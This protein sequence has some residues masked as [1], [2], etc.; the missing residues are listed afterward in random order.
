MRSVVLRF[1]VSLFLLAF[2][3]VVAYPQDLGCFTDN[4]NR[5]L[6][7]WFGYVNDVNTCVNLVR[8]SGLA[9]AGLQSAGE[10]WGGNEL[11]YQRVG[12]GEC[13]M[14]CTNGQTCGGTWRNSVHATGIAP[15][16]PPPSGD[17]V[18]CF[19]DNQY[20]ALP[21]WLGQVSNVDACVSL[22]RTNSLA[23]AGLQAGG[24]CWGGNEVRYQ[25]VGEKECK[26]LCT[27]G[28]ACGG[29]WHNSIYQTG[30]TPPFPPPSGNYIGCFT[31]SQERA[32]PVL[33]GHV[34]DV[35][36]CVSLARDYGFAYA[37]L[38]Y[39]GECWGG[40]RL[41]YSQVEEGKCNTLCTSGQT[42]G[43]TWHNSIY[44]TGITPPLSSGG[45]GMQ[46]DSDIRGCS[47]WWTWSPVFQPNPS[48]CYDYCGQNFAD[49]CE[50]NSF[51][52][53]YVEFGSCGYVQ[54]GFPGWWA[55]VW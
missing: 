48:S 2:S 47:S 11:R 15:P 19:T 38:Q 29:T 22:A 49:A 42:C 55:A 39:Y 26:T 20:R 23:Y 8:S 44:G 28:Q 45:G 5:A 21:Q 36:A 41:G 54:G 18:G 24:E 27:N 1:G 37:G 4:E 14:Q 50:W 17:Y 35:E 10:C 33:V 31:D 34:N 12:A 13:N 46:A 43:G 30:I 7:Q 51:G 53:C 32:L 52:D 40:S 25:Q 6:P 3:A 9:Y 16:I